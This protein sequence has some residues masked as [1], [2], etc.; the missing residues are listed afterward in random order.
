MHGDYSRR[1]DCEV[2]FRE[3][4]HVLIVAVLPKES[5]AFTDDRLLHA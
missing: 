4:F 1:A 3:G 2:A 5:V